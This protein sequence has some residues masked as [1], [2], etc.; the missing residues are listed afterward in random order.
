MPAN[1]HL[2]RVQGA[3]GWGSASKSR[4]FPTSETAASLAAVNLCRA[5]DTD[6]ASV[7]AFDA[8]RIGKHA[9]TIT[10]GLRLD[11]PLEDGRRCLDADEFEEAGLALD[12]RGR[13]HLAEKAAATRAYFDARS[14]LTSRP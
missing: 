5:C 14:A 9:Y 7:A 1:R 8:H 6:F 4:N 10:E 3:P 11:P 2:S 12:G 13:W